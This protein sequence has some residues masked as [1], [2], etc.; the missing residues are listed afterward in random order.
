MAGSVLIT[1][2]QFSGTQRLRDEARQTIKENRKRR[3]FKK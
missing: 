2:L 3:Q 1:E